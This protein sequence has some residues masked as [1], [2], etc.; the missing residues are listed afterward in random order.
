ME[1]SNKQD[2]LASISQR[3]GKSGN[4][5]CKLASELGKSGGW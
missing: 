3:K 5:K 2:V 4:G 1:R